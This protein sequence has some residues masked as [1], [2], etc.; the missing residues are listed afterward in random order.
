[1]EKVDLYRGIG[2]L[3]KYGINKGLI[4][5]SEEYYSVNMLLDIYKE[6]SY[7]EVTTADEPLEEILRILLDYAIDKGIIEDSVTERDLFD[8]RL[9]NAITPRPGT[10]IEEFG[11]LYGDSPEA[12][13]DWFYEFCKDTDYI[14]R[15]RA[16]KDIRWKHKTEFGELDVTIN[17]AKPEKDPKAIAAALSAGSSSYPKCQLCMQ[18]MGYAG[19]MNHPARQTH[20][21]IPVMINGENWGFQ[22]SP[23]GYYNEHCILF[24]GEHV[25]MV[26]NENCFRKMF[27]FIEQFPH[28]MLGSNADLP[29]V[30]G[31]ILTHDHYQGG[32][33]DFA[34][35]KAPVEK[36]F[37]I[38]GFDDISAGIVKWPMSVIRLKGKSVER[39][40]EASVRVLNSWR[41]Y[42]DEEAFIF[43]ETDG[44]VHNTLNPI[45]RKNGD[46]YIIDLILRNNITT[47][48]HP[49]GVYHPHADLHHIKK[50][51]IGI[52][53]AMGLA[54]LP[55][56]LV[57]ELAAV[58]KAILAGD[59]LGDNSLT[60]A[61]AE[62]VE[63]F[64]HRYDHIDEENIDLIIEDEV[65]EV[66]LRVLEDAGVFKRN[67]S[68]MAAFTRFCNSI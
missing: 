33:Y 8:T 15:Y 5:A 25:P 18:N 30:G 31:S 24:N 42:T 66:F 68:G 49:L 60:Q 48:E 54:I 62:W 11:R 19:R 34:M 47:T 57:G 51:N 7:E 20:R 39:L 32:R 37:T 12:A 52:I 21:I 29:I 3:V 64:V 40:V 61:H 13:T 16:V 63:G 22:Y 67:E 2:E 10:V 46:E 53:E 65:G 36:E 50:E 17:L 35:A 14:R 44:A 27:D 1:M 6:D 9:M 28:Y 45:V 38:S 59:N 23:Y 26:I 4:P 58:K 56:R 41:G 43:A 55:S